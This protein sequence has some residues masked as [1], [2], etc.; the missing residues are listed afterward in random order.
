[1]VV[2]IPNGS[3]NTF[4]TANFPGV[5][6]PAGTNLVVELMTPCRQTGCTASPGFPVGDGFATFFGSNNL[7]QSG[8]T[9]IR[10]G[11]G[12]C[13]LND[14][15]DIS[16]IGFPN[17]HIIQLLGT[18]A[19]NNC[20][21]PLPACSGDVTNDGDVDTDDL[22]AVI[23][24]WGD[25]GPPRPQGD[26]APLPNGDCT[27]N[28][29]DLLAVINQWGECELP[30]GA[31]CL[32]NGSCLQVS[33]KDCQAQSGTYNGD[34]SSCG[35]VNC[36][37][38]PLNDNCGGAFALEDGVN[39]V[40]NLNATNSAGV[41][42]GACAFGG[43]VNFT[44][45]VWYTYNATGTGQLTVSA[46]GTTGAV[47]DTVLSIFS[48][49]CGA[50]TELVCDDDSCVAPAPEL[51]STATATINGAGTYYVRIG[52]WNNGPTGDI[53]LEVTFTPIDNDLCDFAQPVAIP[54]TTNASFV[55]ATADTA[56]VCNLVSPAVGR[57][58]SVTGNGNTLT[59]STCVAGSPLWDARL[60]V[61]CGS[62]CANLFC[63]AAADN[64][65][66]SFFQETVSWCSAPGQT[67]WI[68]VSNASGTTDNFTLTI[69]N[70]SPCGNPV[71]CGLANDECQGAITVNNGANLIDGTGATTS[72]NI[73]GGACTGAATNFTNDSWYKYTPTTT[74]LVEFKLCDSALQQDDVLAVLSGTC[75]ALT[76]IGCDD[77]GCNPAT[78]AVPSIAL[79]QV[80]TGVPVFVRVGTWNNTFPG[81][82]RTL[83]ITP[84]A[85]GCGTCTGTL[86]N[87]PCRV[88]GDVGA[89]D[90]N[91][92]CNSEPDAFGF[93]VTS[94]QTVCGVS[95]HY[96][97]STG[98]NSRDTDWYVFVAPA[99]GNYTITGCSSWVG[100]SGLLI[101]FITNG[102]TDVTTCAA[103]GAA[104]FV[105]GAAVIPNN[106]EGSI[107]STLTGGTTY[108]VFAAPGDFT[109][110]VACP[111]AGQTNYRIT[112]TGPN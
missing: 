46:C 49:T 41:P 38:V 87:L 111:A 76:E 13:A 7:G 30:T 17:V 66:C 61:Y 57:W 53:A 4:H 81:G 112:V 14:W 105:A 60:A 29:D 23:N 59:A 48:G 43:A 89:D 64:N 84:G 22:L 101:G 79:A 108:A 42:G 73:P 65:S 63:V 71:A 27:V 88:N 35:T 109:G 8:P 2:N 9:Y 91:G 106:I 77:D 99:D 1:M 45:D 10:T 21:L 74:G 6:I 47:T 103:G 58:Y 97:S 28:T 52:S 31:C 40:T 90:P 70:G 83:T 39:N 102:T 37:V 55:G 51:L 54:S 36:P 75:A 86:E 69:S 95:S 5:A 72:A 24:T 62:S 67:Y 100:S 32:S 96:V 19:T 15:T 80:T 16:A 68:L 44:R 92:G 56:P 94:G 107:T 18:G 82:P 3:A 78:F 12:A 98:A 20:L 85:G 93:A 104:A 50:L 110:G 11:G 34:G 25:V 33:L 26:C